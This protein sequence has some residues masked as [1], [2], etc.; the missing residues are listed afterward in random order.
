MRD[1]QTQLLADEKR[2]IESIL[3]GSMNH[4]N[5]G[6]EEDDD[7]EISFTA[8]TEGLG[9]HKDRPKTFLKTSLPQ[10][11]DRIERTR[12]TETVPEQVAK[13]VQSS[14]QLVKASV[15][16][17]EKSEDIS[18]TI[19]TAQM[20]SLQAF[21][22]PAKNEISAPREKRDKLVVE[23]SAI[24]VFSAWLIDFIFVSTLYVLTV[25]IFQFIA[26][27]NLNIFEKFFDQKLIELQLILFS[28]YY[29]LYFTIGD[30]HHSRSIGK[31][32]MGIHF[33][34]QSARRLSYLQGF[35]VSLISLISFVTLGLAR[36]LGITEKLLN[37][38]V[39]K[40]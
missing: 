24:E 39:I 18:S 36:K 19:P 30:G 10:V 29:L 4:E 32:L 27:Q 12:V 35:G 31:W 3:L 38:K 2:R 14:S 20:G 26:G 17:Q 33:K 11:E 37:L 9:F 7:G 5:D 28:M 6:F 16:Y 40:A 1:E 22:Q 25:L 23:A 34:H 15:S 21:Y 8:I 13:K